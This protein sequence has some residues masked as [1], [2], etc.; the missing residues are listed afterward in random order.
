MLRS[1]I[2]EKTNK[3]F[4]GYKVLD[5]AKKAAEYLFQNNK[6]K[7]IIF[8]ITEITKN[9][10]Y[11]YKASNKD[12]KINI[13]KY[14]GGVIPKHNSY[15]VVYPYS[16][17]VGD[18]V[19]LYD[20]SAKGYISYDMN[21][22][23]PTTKKYI[24]IKTIKNNEKIS[25]P[26]YYGKNLKAEND[27]HKISLWQIVEK[28]YIHNNHSPFY[29]YAFKLLNDN[30]V[31]YLDMSYMYGSLAHHNQSLLF[32]LTEQQNNYTNYF[33][34]NDGFLNAREMRESCEKSETPFAISVRKKPTFQEL[35]SRETLGVMTYKFKRTL[36][37]SNSRK[38]LGTQSAEHV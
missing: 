31:L 27:F 24:I 21:N 22:N 2:L 32:S 16:Y 18:I 12:S 15:N 14:V 35:I 36:S 33:E 38:R 29:K 11:K 23:E 25:I 9:K 7:S 26:V 3:N 8:C 1:F 20:E 30:K 6:K 37:Q 34:I 17:N 13:K 5:V 28:N 10:T 4:Q 19:T